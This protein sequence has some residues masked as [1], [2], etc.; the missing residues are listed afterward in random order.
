[1]RVSRSRVG[2]KENFLEKKKLFLGCDGEKFL[3]EPVEAEMFEMWVVGWWVETNTRGPSED[4]S[5]CG[6]VP[7][8]TS[9]ILV[10]SV[11]VWMFSHV[12]CSSR[13]LAGAHD[14][15]AASLS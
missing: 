4:G 12:F 8:A 2:K 15:L 5:G 6:L 13:H 11:I 10:G 14:W 1:M 3:F 7:K 9:I